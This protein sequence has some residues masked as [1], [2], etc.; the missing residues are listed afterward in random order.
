M[1]L[2]SSAI[3]AILFEEEE[4]ER[5]ARTIE[6]A[7]VRLLSVA[8]WV[9]TSLVVLARKGAQGLGDLERFIL[10]AAIDRVPVDVAS[11][12]LAI[13]AF[14]RFG[15]TRHPARLNFGDCF[16]YALAKATGEPLLFKG[17]DFALTDI[18][19]AAS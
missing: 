6:T 18:A 16:A 1:V 8:N 14:R 5:F 3:I 15:R 2:D 9:E 13:T 10:D 11:G 12:A 7:P 17:G 4:A 19:A